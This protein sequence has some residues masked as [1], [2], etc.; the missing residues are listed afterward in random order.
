[1]Q[2]QPSMSIEPS[3][4][5]RRRRLR[6]SVRG[7][8]VLVLVLGGGFGWFCHRARIQ[9]DAVAAVRHVGGSVIYGWQW[10]DGSFEK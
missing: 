6:I 10:K 3:A 5:P 2:D 1:M 7:L 9:R 4:S 8:M